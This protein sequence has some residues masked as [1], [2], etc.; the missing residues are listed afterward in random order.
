[1]FFLFTDDKLTRGSL[2]V[3]ADTSKQDEVI[4][5][6]KTIDSSFDEPISACVPLALYAVLIH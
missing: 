4:A 3:Q 2:L 6:Y 1:M 5:M